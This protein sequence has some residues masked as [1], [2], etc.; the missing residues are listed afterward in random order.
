MRDSIGSYSGSYRNVSDLKILRACG[1]KV[2]EI[3]LHDC[4]LRRDSAILSPSSQQQMLKRL[5]KTLSQ[6]YNHVRSL[7]PSLRT[8]RLTL[9]NHTYR[10]SSSEEPTAQGARALFEEIERKF[11]SKTLG[12]DRWYLVAVRYPCF[13]PVL[14]PRSNAKLDSRPHRRRSTRIC[15]DFVHPSYRR[16]ALC[17]PRSPTGAS[18]SAERG[19]C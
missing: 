14:N 19:T 16:T 9:I 6:P 12:R 2:L 1:L 10:M 18:S 11:P 7:R 5:Q 17:Y 8:P 4:S 3:V 13:W 15:R